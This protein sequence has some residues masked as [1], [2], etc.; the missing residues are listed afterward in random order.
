M[1]APTPGMSNTVITVEGGTYNLDRLV[2]P[3]GVELRA[4]GSGFLD[5]RVQG[6]ARVEGTINVSGGR[7][8]D[9]VA[10]ADK[11]QRLGGT[12]TG[13]DGASSAAPACT[14]TGGRGG[15]ASIPGLWAVGP[16]TCEGPGTFG[17]G[18]SGGI[19]EVAAQPGVEPHPRAAISEG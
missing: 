19:E 1:L 6:E 4:S 13:Q 10:Q 17:G 8:G 5:L 2:V 9:R 18:A 7:G 12:G 15:S 3:V 14:A 11:T 16:Q